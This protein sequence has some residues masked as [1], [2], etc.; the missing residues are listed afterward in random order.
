MLLYIAL[1]AYVGQSHQTLY[2]MVDIG[3]KGKG[4]ACDNISYFMFCY[5]M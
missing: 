5:C 3:K 1:C 4:S 2:I